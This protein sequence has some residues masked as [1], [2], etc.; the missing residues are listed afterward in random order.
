[1]ALTGAEPEPGDEISREVGVLTRKSCV[2]RADEKPC[3]R[4]AFPPNWNFS[5]VIVLVALSN[6]AAGFSIARPGKEKTA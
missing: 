3:F 4:G 2:F 1:L 5:V 6:L